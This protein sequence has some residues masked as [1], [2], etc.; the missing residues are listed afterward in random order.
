MSV[1]RLGLVM[2]K[3]G[4]G[5]RLQLQLSLSLS[6]SL[7]LGLHGEERLEAVGG[8]GVPWRPHGERVARV[9]VGVGF[10]IRVGV[11]VGVRVGVEVR[12]R[13]EDRE[14]SGDRTRVDG[15]YDFEKVPPDQLCPSDKGGW[16]IHTANSADSCS[17]ARVSQLGLGGGSLPTVSH[18]MFYR[19]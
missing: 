17:C 4:V 6:L 15:L 13:R 12:V 9:G 16:Q 18:S 3:F 10:G 7:R 2:I 19:R 11:K 14:R 5:L 1:L 8:V